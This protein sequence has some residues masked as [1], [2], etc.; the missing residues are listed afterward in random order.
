MDLNYI[1]KRAVGILTDTQATWQVI[2]KSEY[3]IVE[4]YKK[5]LM[6][7]L[8]IPVIGKFI[9][10]TLIGYA[11]PYTNTIIRMELMP[12]LR[13]MILTYFLILS[14]LYVLAVVLIQIMKKFEIN[15]E[16]DQIFKLLSF[17]ATPICL[18]G[19]LFV[20]P[21]FSQLV[22]FGAAYAIYIFYQ[23]ILEF[24]DEEDNQA[25]TITVVASGVVIL[26]WIS[27]EIFLNQFV[28]IAPV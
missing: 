13:E 23:G 14:F 5:Y 10:F 24:V 16:T 22:I 21:G 18:A 12:G 19:V 25:I 9:G 3:G 2:Y 7:I 17:S 20:F 4:I 27:L 28:R 11:L 1:I 6:P 15:A 8:V 26:F